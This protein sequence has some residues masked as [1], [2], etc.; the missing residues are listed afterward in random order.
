LQGDSPDKNKTV[1]ISVIFVETE[2]I[3]DK[4]I[5]IAEDDPDITELLMLYLTSSGFSV[6]TASDGEQALN[7]VRTE[8]I[9]LAL[10]DIMMPKINGYELIQF[11]RQISNIPIII[12]S[13]R[14]M[15]SDKILGLD[16]GADAYITKPF[17]PLEVVAYVKALQRRYYQLG[18]EQEEAPASTILTLGEL[19]LDTEKF[20]LKKRG[21][22][23]QL[24]STELKI[25]AQ[26][27]KC[28]G[29]IF[30]R[31]QLYRCVNGEFFGS[32]SNTMMV[33]ISN[34]RAKL[35]DD[36]SHPRY[37]KT[38]RGLGYKIEAE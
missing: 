20:L 31:E 18:A 5:L 15:D 24:T 37:L 26:L 38:V 36:P 29:R 32:D 8:K 25:I 27:M 21:E 1:I 11:I 23:V 4:P 22:L 12:L 17:N 13:A 19:E 7:I 10:V 33:H 30:T 34:I 3:M 35:E 9:S 14:S 2:A 6:R 16:M 28:P